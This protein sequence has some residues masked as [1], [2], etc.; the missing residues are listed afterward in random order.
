MTLDDLKSRLDSFSSARIA[1]VSKI[2]QSLAEPSRARVATRRTWLT[3]KPEWI[4]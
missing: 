1:F 3:S 2:V 4:E